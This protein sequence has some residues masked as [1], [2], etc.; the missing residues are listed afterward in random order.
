[1]KPSLTIKFN[2]SLY[3]AI[4]PPGY[5]CF[6]ERRKLP[7]SSF[8][9]FDIVGIGRAHGGLVLAVGKHAE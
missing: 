7:A 9:L 1:M 4:L 2:L 8:D 5:I 6:A 3:P